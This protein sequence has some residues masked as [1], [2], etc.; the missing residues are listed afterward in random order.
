MAEVISKRKVHNRTTNQAG[1]P[2]ELESV[3]NNSEDEDIIPTRRRK[4]V[5]QL[6]AELRMNKIKFGK[7][8]GKLYSLTVTNMDADEPGKYCRMSRKTDKR[9]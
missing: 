9:D 8:D 1:I 5:I 7:Q 3:Y 2:E 4:E 6:K